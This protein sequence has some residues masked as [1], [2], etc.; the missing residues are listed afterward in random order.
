MAN[1]DKQQ[2]F[3][4]DSN[5]EDK[6]G[7]TMDL[8]GTKDALENT[9]DPVAARKKQKLQD[10]AALREAKKLSPHDLDLNYLHQLNE[11][12]QPLTRRDMKHET[13]DQALVL[14]YE[15]LRTL[16]CLDL[17]EEVLQFEFEL[18]KNNLF[19][20]ESIQRVFLPFVC[21]ATPVR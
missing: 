3:D 5:R 9:L 2:P 7:S 21:A 1:P 18:P 16:G 19:V 20:E 8:K 17:S 14:S 11:F 6:E 15:D 13:G 4:V 12:G 10:L